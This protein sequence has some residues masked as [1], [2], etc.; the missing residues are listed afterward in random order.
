MTRERLINIL[1]QHFQFLNNC[2]IINLYDNKG[3]LITEDADLYFLKDNKII[4]FTKNNEEF[5]SSNL[6]RIFDFIKKLGQGG[7]GEVYLVKQKMNNKYYVIKF[8]NQD[9][10]KIKDI[11]FLYKEIDILIRLNHPKIIKLY[12]Y[13]ISKEGRLSLIMEYLPGGT[14]RQYIKQHINKRLDENESKNILNQ[15]LEIISYCHKMNIIHHDLKPDNILF[16]DSAHTHIKIIDF[17]ISSIINENNRG[18]SLQ[19]L[20]PEIIFH[21][22]I[23]S[24]PSVDI[25]SIGCIFAEMVKGEKL[26]KG[27]NIDEIKKLISEGNFEF[28]QNLSNSAYDLMEKMLN[29]DPNKRISAEEALVH[30]FFRKSNMNIMNEDS[31]IENKI[32]N[33]LNNLSNEINISNDNLQEGN[34]KN[35]MFKKLFIKNNNLLNLNPKQKKFNIFL[36]NNKNDQISFNNKFLNDNDSTSK[37]HIL[38]SSRYKNIEEKINCSNKNNNNDNNL[39][40]ENYLTSQNSLIKEKILIPKNIKEESKNEEL[41]KNKKIKHKTIT[42]LL[43]RADMAKNRLLSNLKKVE[44]Y[45]NELTEYKTSRYSYGPPKKTQREKSFKRT[46]EFLTKINNISDDELISFWI[47]L[48][49]KFPNTIPNY[50]KPIGLTREQKKKIERFS[51]S[52]EKTKDISRSNKIIKKNKTYRKKIKKYDIKNPTINNSNSYLKNYYHAKY[53]NKLKSFKV[54]NNNRNKSSIYGKLILPNLVNI[55]Q[56]K[57]K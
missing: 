21:K 17:G 57:Q 26:F 47:K 7:F 43:S 49:N 33:D 8:L 40:K 12:S 14:L 56:Y 39:L 32:D 51:K 5:N 30:P 18:G 28:P 3:I 9:F 31:S 13:F 46:P 6:L 20:P 4:F 11:N 36:L 2:K 55:H 37:N 15:I 35:I 23:K 22:N 10:R 53:D 41:V 1:K 38:I 25:W 24:S 16:S 44:N 52:L 34:L 45:K 27:E 54:L 19:Y 42:N 29:F 48:S 50:I